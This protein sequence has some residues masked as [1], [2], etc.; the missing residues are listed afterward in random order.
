VTASNLASGS[1]GDSATISWGAPVTNASKVAKYEILV[2]QQGGPGRFTTIYTVSGTARNLKLTGLPR[3]SYIGVEV[4]AVDA[5][6]DLRMPTFITFV[7][8]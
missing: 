1:T 4:V 8:P 6:G 3:Y 2:T 5:N 7:S